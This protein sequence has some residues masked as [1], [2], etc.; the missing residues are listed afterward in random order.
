MSVVA[1]GPRQHP[2]G[3][4]NRVR[5]VRPRTTPTLTITVDLAAGSMSP[6]LNRL[7]ELLGE[8]A[9]SGE[10]RL[11]PGDVAGRATVDDPNSVRISIGPRT[12]RH[13]DRKIPLTRI[14]Y[15]LL[16][17]LAERPRRVFTRLQLLSSVWGYDHAV[18]RTVDVHVRRLRAKLGADTPLLTTVHGVGYRLA[19]DARVTI[20]P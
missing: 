11:S 17:F 12:V 7:L 5:V 1:I 14:E 18:A 9:E 20:E 4:A 8:I 2:P 13:G 16:L 10:G 15:D 19:D 3:R 6:R